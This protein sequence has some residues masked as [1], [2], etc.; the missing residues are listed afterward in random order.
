[1]KNFSLFRAILSGTI[2]LVIGVIFGA[3][4]NLAV[5]GTSPAWTLTPIC[6]A[7]VLSALAGY[8]LGSRQKNRLPGSKPLPP[9]K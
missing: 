1:M 6:I 3:L 2:G 8:L 4:V 9:G 5:P 7:A